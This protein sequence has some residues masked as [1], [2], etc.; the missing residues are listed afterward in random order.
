MR[1][2]EDPQGFV[3]SLTVTKISE[4]IVSIFI[5]VI[6]PSWLRNHVDIM[7]AG[8]GMNSESRTILLSI[9]HTRG[10]VSLQSGRRKTRSE[11]CTLNQDAQSAV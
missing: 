1:I 4:T 10:C 2:F 8:S 11:A 7:L 6:L 5:L 9:L 3:D